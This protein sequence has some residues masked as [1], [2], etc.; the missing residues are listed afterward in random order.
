[1]VTIDKT[2][3]VSTSDE[4]IVLKGG[5]ANT[6]NVVRIGE[7]VARPT[8][9]QTDSVDHFLR[10]LIDAGAGFVPEPLGT[11]DQG[12]QRLRFLPGV[13][14]VPPYPDWA[15]DESLL[16]AVASHQRQLHELARSYQ[17]PQHAQWAVSAGDYFPAD[18]LTG[19]ETIVCHNDLGMT[20]VIVDAD[21]QMRGFIDFDYCMPVDPLFD[22]AVA[23]RHWAP[24]GDL[25][26]D[27]NEE[28]DRVRRFTVFCDVHS[29]GVADRERVVHLSIEFLNHARRNIKALAAA[30][31]AGFRALLDNGYEETNLA[32]VAWLQVNAGALT[33]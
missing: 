19:A 3:A 18:A 8:Y 22:I 5:R 31:G 2:G 24:F 17:P 28:I 29:L 25:D 10:Y 1:M 26:L 32:T 15:F 14:P 20:N 11:D 16:V 30:G 7:Q 6:G 13:A 23:V 33:R 4:E 27:A 21:H 9:P 12:R